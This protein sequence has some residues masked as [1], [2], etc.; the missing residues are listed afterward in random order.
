[1]IWRHINTQTSPMKKSYGIISAH[2]P[3]QCKNHMA[4]YQHTYLANTKK[5]LITTTSQNAFVRIVLHITHNG[6]ELRLA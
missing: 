1:M 2:K 3:R 5:F 4:S 6:K